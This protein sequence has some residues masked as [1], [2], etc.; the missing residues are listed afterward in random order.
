MTAWQPSARLTPDISVTNAT[1]RVLLPNGGNTAYVFN[2]GTKD[3]FV[4]FGDVTVV[5]VA[6]TSYRVGAG[7]QRQFVIP[8]TA[9]QAARYIAAICAGVDTT[10]LVVEVG[11]GD[12]AGVP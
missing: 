10:T 9:V 6:T 5:A 2:S 11:V 7:A 3:A 1:Q 4:Q 12:Q 8:L